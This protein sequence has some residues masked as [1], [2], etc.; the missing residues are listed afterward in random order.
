[1]NAVAAPPLQML[2]LIEVIQLKWMLAG[3]GVHLHVERLM[4]D[5]SYA[6]QALQRAAA[7]SSP[8]VRALAMR[9]QM[10]VS[11]S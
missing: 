10:R 8:A 3:E 1:M 6:E 5:R 2:S 4:G 9:L 11:S 7:S